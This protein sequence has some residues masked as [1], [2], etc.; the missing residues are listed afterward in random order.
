MA[1]GAGARVGRG[2]DS[3]GIEAAETA[4]EA[5]H[6][7]PS[8]TL[9]N[10]PF[11]VQTHIFSSLPNQKAIFPCITLNRKLSQS[12]R[13]V[14]HRHVDFGDDLVAMNR[15]LAFML[16]RPKLQADVV[17]LG[18]VRLLREGDEE[19]SVWEVAQASGLVALLGILPNL[20]VLSFS[21]LLAPQVDQLVYFS[22]FNDSHDLS[23]HRLHPKWSH[24]QQ[25]LGEKRLTALR[26]HYISGSFQN[27][28]QTCLRVLDLF[29][30]NLSD[31]D[32]RDLVQ[33][34]A[35]TLRRMS[36]FDCRR[37]SSATLNVL[38]TLV[39]HL[40]QLEIESTTIVPHAHFLAP[41]TTL[42]ILEL[43]GTLVDGPALLAL[44]SPLRTLRLLYA[45][46]PAAFLAAGLVR[47]CG[48]PIRTLGQPLKLQLY[49][50]GDAWSLGD[51]NAVQVRLCRS[52]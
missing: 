17:S 9:A 25:S 49:C 14:L 27:L 22:Y 51:W 18:C 44:S 43:E 3:E 5:T 26:L 13:A 48:L 50:A 8:A 29:S 10:L 47:L 36:I 33:P 42:E 35:S 2:Q 45:S 40:E 21:E 24:L 7:L 15:F 19:E 30:S 32:F 39:P 46:P 20:K 34:S 52:P 11:E 23:P 16:G 41:F 6:I 38:G 1:D 12:A 37:L 31:G 28:H 4:T